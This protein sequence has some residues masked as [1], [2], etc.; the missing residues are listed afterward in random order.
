MIR[1][2]RGLDFPSACFSGVE[3]VVRGSCVEVDVPSLVSAVSL[4]GVAFLFTLFFVCCCSCISN[5]STSRAYSFFFSRHTY[6]FGSVNV[7]NL[8]SYSICIFFV[9]FV[10]FCYALAVFLFVCCVTYR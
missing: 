5:R 8:S 9:T 7:F 4:T 1:L 3:A 10:V 2:C 6:I